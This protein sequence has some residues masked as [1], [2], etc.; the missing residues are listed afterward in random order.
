M[1]PADRGESTP[2]HGRICGPHS[3]GGLQS[4]YGT[5]GLGAACLGQVGPT[6]GQT[7]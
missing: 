3:S 4:S 1:P 2:V 7:D 6:D 5:A